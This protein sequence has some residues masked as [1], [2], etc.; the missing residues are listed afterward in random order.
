[1]LLVES[2]NNRDRQVCATLAEAKNLE[3]ATALK[4]VAREDSKNETKAEHEFR[5][6]LKNKGYSDATVKTRCKLL[7]LLEKR[8]ANL[9]DSEDV[10][11][12]IAEQKS[13]CDGHKAIAVQTYSSFAQMMHI[14]WEPP[15]YINV[16][17][18]PFLPLEKE[19][20]ALISGTSPK[21][22]TSLQLIKETGMRI[23]ETW[24]LRWTDLD[25]ER[26]TIRCRVEKHGNP[27]EFKVSPKLLMMLNRL[28]KTNVYIYGMKNISGHR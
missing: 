16:K 18:L 2:V 25:Q 13:W 27:R 15:C 10:K 23:G 8:G 24:N 1:V 20:D 5:T 22:A 6:Y 9:I 14:V 12:V 4:T 26:A 28:Q 21:I 3:H 19:I 7:K 17:S 11:I